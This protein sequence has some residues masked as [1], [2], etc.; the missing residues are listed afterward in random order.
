MIAHEMA[1]V[2]HSAFD[3]PGTGPVPTAR[4]FKEWLNNSS[5]GSALWLIA[6]TSIGPMDV[7]QAMAGAT[8]PERALDDVRWLTR[9]EWSAR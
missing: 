4:T 9:D 1:A 5:D 2:G 7:F 3:Y 8:K 6:N